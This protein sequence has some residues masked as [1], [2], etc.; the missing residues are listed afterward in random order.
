MNLKQ[1][2]FLQ[3]FLWCVMVFRVEK[4]T[5][6]TGKV[7]QQTTL[8]KDDLAFDHGKQSLLLTIQYSKTNKSERST[9]VLIV[10]F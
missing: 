3:H 5:I 8:Q 2:F 10:C 1:R 6:T 9:V 4:L 7:S